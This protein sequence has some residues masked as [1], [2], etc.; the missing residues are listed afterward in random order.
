MIT[1]H[2]PIEEH[3]HYSK[4]RGKGV[5]TIA[6]GIFIETALTLHFDQNSEV[7]KSL[8]SRLKRHL[9]AS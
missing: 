2:L 1:I 4:T 7:A 8:E 9:N 5:S 3:L 6:T